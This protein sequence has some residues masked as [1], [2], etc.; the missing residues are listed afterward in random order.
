MSIETANASP[1]RHGGRLL[2]VAAA[3][4]AVACVRFAVRHHSHHSESPLE[5]SHTNGY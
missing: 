4:L 5:G 3:L 2:L 1:A